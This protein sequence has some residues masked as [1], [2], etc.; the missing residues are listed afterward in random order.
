MWFWS[1]G[2]QKATFAGEGR[3]KYPPPLQ[4]LQQFPSS[5]PNTRPA[6]AAPKR[7]EN[8][9]SKLHAGTASKKPKNE[10]KQAKGSKRVQDLETA[11]DSDPLVESDTTSQSGDDDGISWPSDEEAE[12]SEDW[13]GVGVA[14]NND[15]GGVKIAAEAAGASQ[16]ANRAPKTNGTTSGMSQ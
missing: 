10:E 9:N 2:I 15:D 11:T 7:K 6:M 8:P 3:E 1:S 5:F 12:E 14:E 13:G 4:N 16:S